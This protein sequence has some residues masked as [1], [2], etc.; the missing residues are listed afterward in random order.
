SPSAWKV[1]TVNPSAPSPRIRLATRSRISF[2]DL[3]VKVIAAMRRAG[4][5]PDET[6]CAIFSTITRVLPLPAP[7]STSSGPSTWATAADCWGLRPCIAGLGEAAGHST[8]ALSRA[9]LTH[10]WR[11]PLSA[12]PPP[13]VP[14]PPSEEPPAV[15]PSP[16]AGEGPG[17]GR[18]V[19]A[20][21]TRAARAPSR[22]A[23]REGRNAPWK[24][25]ERRFRRQ[26]ESAH[27]Q[28]LLL[29]LGDER[30]EDHHPAAV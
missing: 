27:G 1:L 19:A 22:P 30:R 17:G 2:A 6:R 21:P 13:G 12:L 4:Y 7:A 15:L 10:D 14:C 5:R 11:A 8:R 29:L 23:I 20:F 24:S 9:V 25:R 16:L 18:P 28:A 26:L 3:L